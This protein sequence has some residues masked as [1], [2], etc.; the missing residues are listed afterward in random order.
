[1]YFF[2]R[3]VIKT[4][5]SDTVINLPK[6]TL[7]HTSVVVKQGYSR[8]ESYDMSNKLDSTL[9]KLQRVNRCITLAALASAHHLFLDEVCHVVEV[10]RLSNR[11]VVRAF[12]KLLPD[13]GT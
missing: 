2:I 4:C 9:Q 11:I 1:M 12:W 8:Q 10:I 13:L 6:R 3:L 7:P 5:V